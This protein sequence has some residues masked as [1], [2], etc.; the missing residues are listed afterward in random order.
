MCCN[1]Q[2]AGLQVGRSDRIV[3]VVMRP[4]IFKWRETEP[5]PILCA[6]GI[7]TA[8]GIVKGLDNKS[9]G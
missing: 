7:R 6:V 8:L 9:N 4:A 1:F 5:G 3:Q 2:V